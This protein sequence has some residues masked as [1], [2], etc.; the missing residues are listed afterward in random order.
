[1]RK[2]KVCKR[3]DT[4]FLIHQTFLNIFITLPS[5]IIAETKGF[6]KILRVI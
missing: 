5:N 3:L 2:I 4:P 6:L 1:M